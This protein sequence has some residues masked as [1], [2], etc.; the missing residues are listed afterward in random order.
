MR[1]SDMAIC[2]A[3][4]AWRRNPR[5]AGVAREPVRA[6]ARGVCKAGARP[7]RMAEIIEAAMVNA[8]TRASRVA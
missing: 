2:A 6:S 7:Q 5:E 3:A 4:R 1:V 8:R